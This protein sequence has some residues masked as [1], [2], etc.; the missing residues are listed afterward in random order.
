MAANHLHS[1]SPSLPLSLSLSL[2][3]HLFLDFFR[4]SVEAFTI[5]LLKVAIML[6]C[7]KL[8]RLSLSAASTLAYTCEEEWTPTLRVGSC[9]GF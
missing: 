1:L 7:R 6:N 2:S 9:N 4:I 3:L 5:D 8:V